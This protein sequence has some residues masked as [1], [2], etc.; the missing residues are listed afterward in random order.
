[1]PVMTLYEDFENAGSMFAERIPE[2]EAED[3]EWG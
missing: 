3:P 1:M 2:K